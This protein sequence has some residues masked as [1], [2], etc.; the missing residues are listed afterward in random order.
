[1]PHHGPV[2]DGC[3]WPDEHHPFVPGEPRFTAE[4]DRRLLLAEVDRLA[5]IIRYDWSALAE[6][7][8]I[9]EGVKR[10]KSTVALHTCWDN[11]EGIGGLHMDG[12]TC[13]DQ[14]YDMVGRSDVLAVVEG[15][16]PAAPPCDWCD[17]GDPVVD[18]WHIRTDPEGIDPTAKVPCPRERL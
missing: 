16:E 13:D 7:E 3:A 12:T 5:D 10:L 9:S 6:R 1:M 11:H 17:E 18:G 4:T 8:R 14:M 2:E 15:G